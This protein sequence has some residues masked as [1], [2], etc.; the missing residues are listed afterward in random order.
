MA[1]WRQGSGS[2]GQTR[3]VVGCAQAQW[4]GLGSAAGLQ[5]VRMWRGSARRRAADRKH[6]LAAHREM[7]P[8]DRFRCGSCLEAGTLRRSISSCRPAPPR[9]RTRTRFALYTPHGRARRDRGGWGQTIL[10][11]AQYHALRGE[12]V[13]FRSVACLCRGCPLSEQCT[14]SK[15]GRKI[16]LHERDDL[17]RR[18]RRDWAEQPELREK[19]RKYRPNVERVISQVASR[20]SRR[21]KLRYRGTTKNHAW[22]ARRTAGLNLRNL[23]GRGLTRSAGNWVLATQT[24]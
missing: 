15:T 1:A 23:V 9:L 12:P 7:E 11:A 3:R 16:V 17:L 2:T 20:G 8:G 22:L 21:L 4:T 6:A 18:A 10:Y 14:K 24:T 13:A 19:Y 5:F